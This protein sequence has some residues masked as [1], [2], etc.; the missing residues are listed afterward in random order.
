M[1]N[2]ENIPTNAY[3]ANAWCH[4]NVLDEL[5]ADKA[6]ALSAIAFTL[7][8][9]AERV[10]E[11]KEEKDS[12]VKIVKVPG[13]KLLLCRKLRLEQRKSLR[14]FA[15]ECGM[16]NGDVSKIERGLMDPYPVQAIKMAYYL[17]YEGDPMDL[18]KEVED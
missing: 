1:L 11:S 13:D 9:L 17:G 18:F 12:K 16:G 3:L 6:E 5:G 7:F 10:L 8:A 15:I 4:L 2:E 14:K